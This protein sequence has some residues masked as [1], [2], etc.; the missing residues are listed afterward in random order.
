M[1]TLKTLGDVSCIFLACIGIV[2]ICFFAYYSIFNNDITVGVN[3]ISDQLAVDI[4]KSDDLSQ[5]EKDIYEERW[6]M[7]A[8]YYDNAKDN[9]VELQELQF[10][11]FMTYSLT[12]ADYR[13]S[14]MQYLGDYEAA[15]VQVGSEDEANRFRDSNFYYYDTT[16][17]ISWSGDNNNFGSIGTKLDRNEVMI[18]KID[19]RPFAIQLDGQ[20]SNTYKKGYWY[21]LGIPV[22]HTETFY[23]NY[24]HVFDC[25]FKAIKSNDKGYGDYYIT[26]DL[27]EFFSIREYDTASGQFKAD[28]VTDIIKNYAVLKFHYEAN[29]AISSNQSLYGSIEC[30]SKYDLNK[31]DYDTTYWQERMVYNL[32]ANDLSLRYSEVSNG[33]FASLPLSMQEIFKKMGRV[34]VNITLDLVETNIVGFDFNAFEGFEIDTI[35]LTGTNQNFHFSEKSL[36]NSK[37]KAIKRSSGVTLT[38]GEN[39]VNNAYTEVVL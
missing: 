5:A 1:K 6:F 38:F 25:V 35:T 7:R 2:I 27:S 34:K 39:A 16:N 26:L 11:Y 32:T 17:G 36:Y 21:T 13:S 15:W 19:N 37:L 10:N 9:G 30:N 28:N 24:K 12:Q 33:A 14:G 3:N 8:N 22:K 4:V 31:D 29:G 20:Y 23:Y 18:I